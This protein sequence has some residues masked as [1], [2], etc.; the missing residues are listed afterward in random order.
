[1]V[2]HTRDDLIRAARCYRGIALHAM[3]ICKMLVEKQIPYLEG[4]ED[5]DFWNDLLMNLTDIFLGVRVLAEEFD[6]ILKF[7][8][9]EPKEE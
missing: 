3:N 9:V 8:D 2:E 5:A 4:D 7:H 1:M 6:D